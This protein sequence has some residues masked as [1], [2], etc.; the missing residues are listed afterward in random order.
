MSVCVY[1]PT[2]WLIK[3]GCVYV[4]ECNI[5]RRWN[6]FAQKRASF[7]GDLVEL[8]THY[9]IVMLTI[10]GCG[11]GCGLTSN[12]SSSVLRSL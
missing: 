1:T 11:S 8:K 5:N 2:L 9:L 4:D 7:L 3:R 12:L 6:I 10:K